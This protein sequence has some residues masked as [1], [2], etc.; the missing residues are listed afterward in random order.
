MARILVADDELILALWLQDVLAD[1][2][3]QV[4]LASDGA[5]ALDMALALAPEL[6]I[7]DFMMPG[8]TGLELAA[9]I[10]SDE[11][12]AMTPI[13]LV[14]GAQGD[15]ARQRGDLFQ[16]VFDK[17]YK[18]DKLVMELNRILRLPDPRERD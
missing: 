1:E 10:R 16:A 13:I 4:E 3:H 15:L 18:P 11:R 5:A 8:L 2:G 7:T 17:P 14:S 12:L 9:A 6:V